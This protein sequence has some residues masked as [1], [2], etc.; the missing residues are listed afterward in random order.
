MRGRRARSPAYSAQL[1]VDDVVVLERVAPLVVPRQV[2]HVH[3]ERRALDVAQE[4]V[5]QPAPLVRPLDEAGDVGRHEAQV[6]A[7]GHAQ[8]GHERGER[9]VGDLRPGRADARDERGLP[10]RGHAYQRRVGHELHSQLDPAFLGRLSQ[11]GER[12]GTPGG[13]HEVDVA[14][15]ADAALGHGHVLAVV[16]EVG[17]ELAGFL[18]LVEVFAHHRANRHLEHQVIAR[19]TVHARPFAVRAALGLEVVLEAV[20]DERGQAGVGLDDHVAAMPAVAAVRA[21]LGHVRLAAERHT[22]RAAITALHVYAHL[23]YEQK[24]L[25]PMRSR[26]REPL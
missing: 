3:D 11:L 19:G 2:H 4:L 9:V 21:A 7:G 14:P 17:D 13:R 16:R 26:S 1:A 12:R 5:S 15:P 6:A 20:I 24:S 18:G 10:R 22:A 23:V 25:F 8:V